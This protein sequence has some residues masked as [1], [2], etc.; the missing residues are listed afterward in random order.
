MM[1]LDLSVWWNQINSSLIN[2]LSQSLNGWAELSSA[3][4]NHLLLCF[5]TSGLI[6]S[7][8]NY[9]FSFQKG[10]LMDLHVFVLKKWWKHAGKINIGSRMCPSALTVQ[11]AESIGAFRA[12][13]EHHELLLCSVKTRA[14]Q[15]PSVIS[16][17]LVLGMQ[18]LCDV[19]S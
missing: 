17:F 11:W 2:S 14:S 15:E 19:R 12:P 5:H 18:P 3:H 1:I 8:F 7:Y 10:H 13:G 4:V 9:L 16:G 6:K